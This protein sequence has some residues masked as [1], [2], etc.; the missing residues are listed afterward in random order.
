MVD[1]IWYDWQNRDVRNK[2]A[3]GGGSVAATDSFAD[4]IA[5]PNGHSPYYGV[6]ALSDTTF[7]YKRFLMHLVASLSMRLFSPVTACGVM[8]RFGMSWIPREECSATLTSRQRLTD[9]LNINF[10]LLLFPLSR[11]VSLTRQYLCGSKL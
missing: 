3:F 9:V 10:D 1:K 8:L 7:F 5:F 6:S 11:F 4:F 2:L